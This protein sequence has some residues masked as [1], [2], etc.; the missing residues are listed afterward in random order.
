MKTS[1]SKPVLGHLRYPSCPYGMQ[2]IVFGTAKKPFVQD[3]DA[4]GNVRGFV[5]IP[6]LTSND[7]VALPAPTEPQIGQPH[8]CALVTKGDPHSMLVAKWTDI[9]GPVLEAYPAMRGDLLKNPVAGFRLANFIL[10]QVPRYAAANGE[11][12]EP[13]AD[14]YEFEVHRLRIDKEHYYQVSPEVSALVP[15]ADILPK[16]PDDHT[17]T[18]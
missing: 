6:A 14:G 7:Y 3:V 2:T 12:V 4:R 1:L 17:P 15:D 18:P 16:G 11:V 9:S 13:G 5:R 10:G 8:F